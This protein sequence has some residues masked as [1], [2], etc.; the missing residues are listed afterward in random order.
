MFLL[1]Y[2]CES[3]SCFSSHLIKTDIIQDNMGLDEKGCKHR[4]S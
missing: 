2:K 1:L 4:L 3:L